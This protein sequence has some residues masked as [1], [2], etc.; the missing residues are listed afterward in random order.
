MS[1]TYDGSAECLSS[2]DSGL[3]IRA[4]AGLLDARSSTVDEGRVLAETAVVGIRAVT[5]RQGQRTQYMYRR[6]LVKNINNHGL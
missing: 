2:G 6:K 4:C 3:E 1:G 5:S